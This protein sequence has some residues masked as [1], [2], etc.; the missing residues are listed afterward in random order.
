MRRGRCEIRAGG[1]TSAIG[2][3]AQ[4][5]QFPWSQL[6]SGGRDHGLTKPQFTR[7]GSHD[8]GLPKPFS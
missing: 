4:F 7:R 1:F 5:A 6:P 8:H 2:N 3:C